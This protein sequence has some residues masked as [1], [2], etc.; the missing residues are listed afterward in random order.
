MSARHDDSRMDWRQA[1]P[2][3]PKPVVDEPRSLIDSWPF[4]LSFGVVVLA[5]VW[6]ASQG[7]LL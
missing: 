4:L 3:D 1:R 7:W 5:L 6:A 2:G